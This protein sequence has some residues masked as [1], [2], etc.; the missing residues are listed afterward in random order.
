MMAKLIFTALFIAIATAATSNVDEILPE[1]DMIGDADSVTPEDDTALIQD[2]ELMQDEEPADEDD[3]L[4]QDEALS[5]AAA[6]SSATK[7]EAYYNII[8]NGYKQNDFKPG[9]EGYST[10]K[11]CS[12]YNREQQ[13][14]KKLITDYYQHR[15]SGGK[16]GFITTKTG[17]KPCRCNPATGP[18]KWTSS[19][20]KKCF[21]P[22][23]MTASAKMQF[24]CGSN[25][26]G[27]VQGCSDPKGYKA[28]A[29]APPPMKI[30]ACIVK[31]DH[32]PNKSVSTDKSGRW[33]RSWMSSKFTSIQCSGCKKVKLF[34]DDENQ[35]FASVQNWEKKNCGAWS[36]TLKHDL[37]DDIKKVELTVGCH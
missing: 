10:Y 9:N 18:A 4:M 35:A 21:A 22:K 7:S 28:A 33:E 2:E 24:A 16:R 32:L 12:E 26:F 15:V 5:S 36:Y 6:L 23:E 17:Q 25:G 29:P 11:Y 31:R 1:D 14:D 20:A 27:Y 34:D 8:S 13:W 30:C 19:K 37:R 3:E